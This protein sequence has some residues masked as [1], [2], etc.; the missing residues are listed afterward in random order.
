[1]RRAA[2]RAYTELSEGLEPFPATLLAELAPPGVTGA[3]AES[4]R[5]TPDDGASVLLSAALGAAA[6]VL[7]GG[8]RIT[9]A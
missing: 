4:D 5:I 9:A 6:A 7:V 2:T 1:M 3:G 8:P